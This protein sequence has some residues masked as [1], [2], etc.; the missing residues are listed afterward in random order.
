MSAE[1]DLA[2]GVRAG[3]TRM[4]ARA[5]SVVED[6]GPEAAA[7]L[8]ALRTAKPSEASGPRIVLGITGA[9]G[10]GKSSV[11]AELLSAYRERDLSVAVLAVD[12]SSPM[13]GGAVL[14]DRVR[15]QRHATDAKVFIR[16]MAAR[17]HL[18]GLSAATG[19]AIAVL[20]AAGFEV[21]IVETVGVGQSEVDIASV[22]DCV[23][24]VMAPGMGDSVQAAKA[25]VLEIGDILVVNKAD[26]DGAEATARELRQMVALGDA[27]AESRRTA[28]QEDQSAEL[29]DWR[30]RVVLTTAN[31]DGGV[32]ALVNAIDAHQ[33]W[34]TGTQSRG[35]RGLQRAQEEILRMA[36]SQ[37]RGRLAAAPALPSLAEQVVAGQLDVPAAAAL[38]RDAPSAS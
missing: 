25:G 15:M 33:D 29:P 2:A 6:G 14:G 34:L 23:V 38:L 8:A 11:V 22:C 13:T 31:I 24:I 21:V 18:G 7:L 35:R 28:A 36:L 10:A 37:E 1:S 3:H 30:Q 20:Q 19:Q 26:R 32:T 27:L 16:S 4:L 5:I 12:P 17:G 9:P